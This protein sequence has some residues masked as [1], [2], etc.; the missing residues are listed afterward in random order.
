M[1]KIMMAL[2]AL[3]LF[4]SIPHVAQAMECCKDGICECCRPDDSAAEPA[5]EIHDQH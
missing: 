2:G 1:M 5:G 4:A 3:A